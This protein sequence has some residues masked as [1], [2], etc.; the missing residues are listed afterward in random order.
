MIQ[1]GYLLCL[2]ECPGVVPGFRNA[3]ENESNVPPCVLH[4][5]K[6]SRLE[7]V[8][9]SWHGNNPHPNLTWWASLS[10]EPRIT[11]SEK[12]TSNDVGESK[13]QKAELMKSQKTSW[14]IL[15][16]FLQTFSSTKELLEQPSHT[17]VTVLLPSQWT[18]LSLI[19]CL[20]DTSDIYP[21]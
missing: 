10:R 9:V 1:G 14:I 8:K 13:I 11:N 20:T 16:T 2:K 19:A 3:E 18:F 5:L 12:E 6:W 7:L 15:S 4:F 17:L 21:N